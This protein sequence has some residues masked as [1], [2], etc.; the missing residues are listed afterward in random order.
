MKHGPLK[1]LVY[2][3]GLRNGTVEDF[4][5]LRFIPQD[6]FDNLVTDLFDPK[7]YDHAK[8]QGL[9]KGTS[10][11]GYELGSNNFITDNQYLN[12]QYQ[13]TKPT[14]IKVTSNYYNET[15]T[16]SLFA[17]ETDPEKTYA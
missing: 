12:V 14:T 11:E 16:Y 13:S 1:K 10:V 6:E 8:L 2:V 4:P 3:D 17:G 7:V 9:T 5:T 15:Y